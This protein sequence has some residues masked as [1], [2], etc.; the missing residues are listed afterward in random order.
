MQRKRAITHSTMKNNL[1]NIIECCNN[2]H[3][4]APHTGKEMCAFGSDLRDASDVTC[5]LLTIE[6]PL[7]L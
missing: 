4:G 2:T 5:C 1:C 6:R 7:A 3:Q